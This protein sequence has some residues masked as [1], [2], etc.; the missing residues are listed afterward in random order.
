M[1]RKSRKRIMAAR[2]RDERSVGQEVQR[3]GQKNITKN[4]GGQRQKNTK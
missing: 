1:T 2:G 3:K 4:R